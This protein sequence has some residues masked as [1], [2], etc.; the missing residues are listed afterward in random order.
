MST[1]NRQLWPADKI[2]QAVAALA[3][4]AGVLAEARTATDNTAII[5]PE[6]L[7]DAT[8]LSSWV[9]YCADDVG[10]EA[11]PIIL[12]YGELAE[13]L[14]RSAPILLAVPARDPHQFVAL[15]KLTRTTA[16]LITP[17]GSQHNYP[18]ADVLALFT[19]SQEAQLTEGVDGLLAAI[20]VPSNRREAA[21][22]GI[23][24]Q[25]L[26][27]RPVARG[28]RIQP[29]PGS[30][31]WRQIRLMNLH[32]YGLAVGLSHFVRQVFFVT[33]WAVLGSAAFTGDITTETLLIFLALLLG[34]VAAQQ[35]ST[36]CQATLQADGNRLLYRRMMY[37][38]LMM[39]PDET[40]A[41]GT[42]QLLGR[43]LEV[44][45][46]DVLLQVSGGVRGLTSIVEMILALGVLAIGAGAMLQ[47]GLLLGWV[48]LCLGVTTIFYRLQTNWADM[49]R[50]MTDDLV[51]KLLGH[52]TRLAQQP[53]GTWHDNEDQLLNDYD[54]LSKQRDNLTAITLLILERGWI[55]VAWLSLLPLFDTASN[56]RLAVII[57]GILLAHRAFPGLIGGLNAFTLAYVSWQQIKEV[58]MLPTRQP[59]RQALFLPPHTTSTESSNGALLAVDDVRFHY[60]RRQLFDGVSLSIE[61]DARVFLEGGS[62]SGKTTLAA[63]MS[64]LRPIQGGDMTLRGH[65]FS[66]VNSQLWRNRVVLVPQFHENH[67]FTETFLFNALMGRGY[68]PTYED[69]QLAEQICRELGLDGLLD[70]MPLGMSQIVGE[71][72]WQLSHGEK[73][74][75]YVARGLLQ[76]ADLLI[77][78]ESLAALDPENIQRVLTCIHTHANATM[79]IAHP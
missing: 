67:V 4:Q 19:A 14:R 28:W 54:N 68:P 64:G 61:Q 2:P 51:E 31:F 40:R 43:N 58:F 29:N 79:I 53:P 62:G 45:N 70:R 48:A 52:R 66:A 44:S 10:A 76:G 35:F 39:N 17:D 24:N 26:Y 5:A 74:R 77:L 15:L 13:E 7:A 59:K 25:R 6:Q 11:E 69:V 22:Q 65:Q 73:S 75:L 49:R 63:L 38:T 72:G 42:G 57:G 30:N 1:L 41:Q 37:G 34:D 9:M 20:D 3:A 23:F 50:T 47:A 16:T 18:A 71:T 33:A 21:R 32:Y 8:T 46:F 12:T 60:D 78:D 56:E 55:V 27:K 36:Y